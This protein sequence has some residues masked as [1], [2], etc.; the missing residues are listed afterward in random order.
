MAFCCPAYSRSQLMLSSLNHS[1]INSCSIS[2]DGQSQ[3]RYL[4]WAMHRSTIPIESSNCT[5]T[6][7]SSSYIC[8]HIPRDF[9]PIEEFFAELKC[10]IKKMWSTFK[11]TPK[12]SFHAFVQWCVHEVGARKESSEGHFRQA[13]L[14]VERQPWSTKVRAQLPPYRHELLSRP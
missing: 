3:S 10:Y 7:G 13:G 5:P 6:Q 14:T 4:L 2:G 8:R 11:N 9:N 1:L 12:E